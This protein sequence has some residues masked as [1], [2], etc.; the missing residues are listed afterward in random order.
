V[1][2]LTQRSQEKLAAAFR[3]RCPSISGADLLRTRSFLERRESDVLGGIGYRVFVH[4]AQPRQ[5][6]TVLTGTPSSS[7]CA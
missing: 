6:A 2:S 7:S 4:D 3:K 1:D 5:H